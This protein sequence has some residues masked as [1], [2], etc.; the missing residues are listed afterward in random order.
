MMANS[1]MPRPASKKRPARHPQRN[2]T[3]LNPIILI[4]KSGLVR[5]SPEAIHPDRVGWKAYGLSSLPPEWVPRFV[6]IDAEC[7][8]G[9]NAEELQAVVRQAVSE[10]GLNGS[11]LF[12]RSSGTKETIQYRGRLTS[13]RCTPDVI[14]TRIKELIATCSEGIP[15]EIHWI[16][17]EY[18][19]SKRQGHLSNARMVSREQRDWVAEIDLVEG[20]PGYSMHVAVRRWRDGNRI[21]D[22]SLK[23]TSELG[24]SFCLKRVAM[25]AER[26]SSRIHFEWVWNGHSIRIVQ[27]DIADSASGVDPSKLLPDQIQD[28]S[29]GSLSAFKAATSQ[30]Y[31]RYGK[32]RNAK[33]YRGFCYSM[34]TFY[35]LDDPKTLSAILNGT[36]SSALERDLV[37]LTKRPLILRTDGTN[38]PNDKHEMLPRSETLRTAD[39][40]KAWLA[41][42][43]KAEIERGGLR[44]ASLCLIGHH[45]IPSIASAWARAEP[46]NRVVRIEALWGLPEGLYWYSHDTFEVDTQD[47]AITQRKA[48]TPFNFTLRER[49]RYKG[50]FIAPD[51][52]GKWIPYL[53]KPPF[54]WR[55]S[56]SK[57]QSLFEIAHTTRLIAEHEKRSISA[58]WF[59]GNHP[60]ATPHAVL[61]WFHSPS[62][63]SGAPKAAPRR[64][65]ATSLDLKLR[66]ASDWE[67]LKQ[68]VE[69][70]KRI[71]RVMVEPTDCDLIRNPD[72]AI[73]LANLAAQNNIVIELAG[74]VLSHAYYI[75]RRQGA[76]V[77]CADLFGAE[78]DVVEYNK[79]VRDKIPNTIRARGE[80]VEVVQLT[81]EALISALRQ[82][83]VEESL[84]ALDAKSGDDLVG[85]LADV[86][87]VISGLRRAIQLP[88]ARIEAERKDKLKRR[89]GFQHGYMLTRTSTPHSLQKQPANVDQLLGLGPLKPSDAKISRQADIPASAVYR[90][91]DLRQIEQDL[92][93]LFV[94]ETEI[95]RILDLSETVDFT[96]P[97]DDGDSRDFALTVEIHR[98]RS[99]LRSSVRLRLRPSQRVID[100]PDPQLELDFSKA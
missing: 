26:L 28:I 6:V 23:C 95:N 16:V 39:E 33:L 60:K 9:G 4:D 36:F 94:F 47:I 19:Q 55:P 83:L 68:Q 51:N 58:M 27:A 69:A 22:V 70:G 91:P 73:N 30:Q 98:D 74:G 20:L 32:L 48:R 65:L 41:G 35:V 31:N 80:H 49:L 88:K 5:L 99:S 56:I 93:K 61:P 52:A 90:R 59:I 57:R 100:F 72:F 3:P 84:E 50:T 38:I 75:L 96:L 13:G 11:T 44:E 14:V 82:K 67:N 45:F 89:G 97:F 53:T 7:F 63:L 85:E 54:D 29:V 12:L 66:S 71:E 86:E 2:L 17:Q 92:E 62:E 1:T 40:A 76:Q 78:E 43:F 87:E 42:K 64:K 8:V 34:P 81:G 79:L 10:F 25:W 21:S 77:E 46:G 37:E 24:I 15:G 18:V